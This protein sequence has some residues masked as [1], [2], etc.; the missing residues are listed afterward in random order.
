MCSRF[1]TLTLSTPWTERTNRIVALLCVRWFSSIC[2]AKGCCEICSKLH[3]VFGNAVHC[4]EYD[5][6]FCD[7]H[8][9]K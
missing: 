7:K 1:V 3:D 4:L 6:K 2:A 9:E 5:D 8:S